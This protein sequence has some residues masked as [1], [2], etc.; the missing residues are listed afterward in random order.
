MIRR[1]PGTNADSGGV[2]SCEATSPPLT[3]QE[4][5]QLQSLP[6]EMQ[7]VYVE[8]TLEGTVSCNTEE[9]EPLGRVYAPHP[10]SDVEVRIGDFGIGK[11]V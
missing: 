6:Q 8:G 9:L 5:A 11:K 4:I 1:G 3:S 2:R 7:M 10:S